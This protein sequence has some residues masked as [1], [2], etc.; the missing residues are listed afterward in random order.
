MSDRSSEPVC[1]ADPPIPCSRWLSCLEEHPDGWPALRTVYS[2][3]TGMVRE[4]I[5]LIRRMLDHFLRGFGDLP[6][7]LYRAPGRINLRGMH[8]DTHG[9]W[10]NLQAHHGE[11]LAAAAV[12]DE[13][14][15]HYANLWPGDSAFTFSL[16]PAANLLATAGRRH[17]IHEPDALADPALR[18]LAAGLPDWGRYVA[19]AAL[20]ARFHGVASPDGLRMVVASDLIRGAS[21]SSS[22]SLCVAVLLAEWGAAG[23]TP[24]PAGLMQAVRQ[25]EWFAGARTGLSD[26]AAIV[27]ARAGSVLHAALGGADLFSESPRWL[28][29][30]ENTAVLVI[31]TFTTRALSGARR[32]DYARN[33]FAY[34]VALRM[35]ESAA[36]ARF[37]H[38]YVPHFQTFPDVLKAFP[39]NWDRLNLIGALPEELDLSELE[40]LCGTETVR[41]EYGRLFGDLP[42]P[43]RPTRFAIRGPIL[44]GLA[45]TL[46]A[47]RF[48]E[49]LESGDPVRAGQLMRIGHDGDRVTDAAGRS[50]LEPVNNRVLR[51]W[52]A[53]NRPLE[54]LP[55]HYGASTRALDRAVDIAL[56]AGAVGAC[57]TGAGLGGAVLALCRKADVEEVRARILSGLASRDFQ[58]ARG[59]EAPPW[60]SDAGRTA[61]VENTAVAGAGPI[62]PPPGA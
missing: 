12:T 55:G 39:D 29:M 28:P 48:F 25:A 60:P 62:P 18:G 47:R 32:V 50:F 57:L 11:T 44:F 56:S 37:S 10:L 33:R 8:I 54:H 26:Q 20:A 7:R 30:P 52:L 38:P 9:G 46:R 14:E 58:L 5:G 13:P 1:P 24:D 42:E 59:P 53:R 43:E 45:E 23:M 2:G 36:A 34:S 22:A 41:E 17:S 27:L 31:H 51:L 35:L 49:A 6:V 21:L 15:R 19:G 16:R 61:V 40:R 4:K 3:Q